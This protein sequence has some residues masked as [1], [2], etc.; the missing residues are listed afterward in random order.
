M[1][2]ARSR[3]VIEA[4]VLK[5]FDSYAGVGSKMIEISV[6]IDHAPL[7]QNPVGTDA[8][9]LAAPLGCRKKRRC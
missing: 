5:R 4:D 8:D 1:N 6:F 7:D 2:A 9:I 3:A